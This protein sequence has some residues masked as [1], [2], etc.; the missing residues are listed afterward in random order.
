M[1]AADL[2]G[3]IVRAIVD[4]PDEVSVTESVGERITTVELCV[5]K[6]DTGKII[7]KN[8]RTIHALRIVLAAACTRYDHRVLLELI[9]DKTRPRRD[10]LDDERS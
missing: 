3:S 7:G 6:G 10:N 2:I 9:D 5:A 8:G 1:T 4:R